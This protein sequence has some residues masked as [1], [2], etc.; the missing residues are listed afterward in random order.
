[1]T[2]RNP[3]AAVQTYKL[4]LAQALELPSGVGSGFSL[5]T[6]WDTGTQASA[7]LPRTVARD[8][9]LVFE[10]RPFETVTIELM[11]TSKMDR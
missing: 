2:L 10:L 5:H 1:V 7:R 11:P 9:E 3:S 6:V 4:R 8:A